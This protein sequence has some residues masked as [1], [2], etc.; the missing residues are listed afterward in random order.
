MRNLSPHDHLHL[1]VCLPVC[2][3]VCRCVC[4]SVGVS[5]CLF[6][7]L[8]ISVCLSVRPSV[9]R[10][11]PVF[12]ISCAPLYP[13]FLVVVQINA[14]VVASFLRSFVLYLPSRRKREENKKHI[15]QSVKER[16][17]VCW[18]LMCTSSHV[19]RD[20]TNV[21]P[22][23]C[24]PA[25]PVTR[26]QC[27]PYCCINKR[28]NNERC[29]NYIEYLS[30]LDGWVSQERERGVGKGTWQTLWVTWRGQEKGLLTSSFKRLICYLLYNFKG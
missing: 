13:L 11:L 3:S 14:V 20:N 12:L 4:L 19:E 1:L 28:T 24:Q 26:E 18:Y 23:I 15:E 16:Q 9:C 10:S 8:S 25:S 29:Y 6:I 30:I 7:C 27:V 5:V 17:K 21:S 2:L 22:S